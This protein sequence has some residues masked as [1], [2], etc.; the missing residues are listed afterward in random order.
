M[1]VSPELVLV[2]PVLREAAL[3]ALPM[4]AD[5]LAGGRARV[6][7]SGRRPL[8]MVDGLGPPERAPQAERFDRQSLRA[9][10]AERD[11]GRR[12]K[13]IFPLVALSGVFGFAYFLG[14][15]VLELVEALGATLPI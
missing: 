1:T 9:A 4:P 8:R 7:A 15:P 2:D 6:A 12:L 5:C 14:P 13:A 3:A 10:A 11:T